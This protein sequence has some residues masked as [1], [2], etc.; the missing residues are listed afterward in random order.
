MN[1]YVKEFFVD[2]GIAVD[3]DV[4]SLSVMLQWIWRSAIRDGN[5]INIYLPSSRMRGLL[6]KWLNNEM[7]ANI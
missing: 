2:N 6:L 4:Y 5:H 3:E 1:P 7:E